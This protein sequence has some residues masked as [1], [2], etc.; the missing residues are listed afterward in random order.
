MVLLQKGKCS[1]HYFVIKSKNF[2]IFKKG[3][4]FKTVFMQCM[5]IFSFYGRTTTRSVIWPTDIHFWLLPSFVC[6]FTRTHYAGA[7]WVNLCVDLAVFDGQVGH[8]GVKH[9][10]KFGLSQAACQQ[11]GSNISHSQ[12]NNTSWYVKHTGNQMC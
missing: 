1:C 9:S 3:W 7:A 4:F 5:S 11:S 10:I 8:E 6:L 2:E 12:Y